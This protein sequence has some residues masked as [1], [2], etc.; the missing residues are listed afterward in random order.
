MTTGK[1]NPPELTRAQF[2]A[3]LVERFPAV[4]EDV[5]EDEGLIHLQVG[6]LARYVNV[7]IAKG[8]LDE[9][10]RIINYFQQTVERVDS[11]TENALYVA[12][13]EHLVFEGESE[14]AQHARMLLAP[15]YR[16]IWRQLRIGR[17]Q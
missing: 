1:S 17:N 5:L 2:L 6:S 4:A 12:F 10:A 8:R 13:L 3:G 14:N 7:C 9:V 16:D 15:Q 11:I